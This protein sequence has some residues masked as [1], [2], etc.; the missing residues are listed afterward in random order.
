MGLYC[1]SGAQKVSNLDTPAENLSGA[2]LFLFILYFA[3]FIEIVLRPLEKKQPI[4]TT[5]Y[6]HQSESGSSFLELQLFVG[7]YGAL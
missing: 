3:C 5:E 2:T 7:R 4:P 6:Y 1:A